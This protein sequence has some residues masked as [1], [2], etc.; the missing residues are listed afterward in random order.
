MLVPVMEAV[1]LKGFHLCPGES[2]VSEARI[3]LQINAERNIYIYIYIYQIKSNK[4][5]PHPPQNRCWSVLLRN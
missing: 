3:H 4:I 2:S 1:E 5:N